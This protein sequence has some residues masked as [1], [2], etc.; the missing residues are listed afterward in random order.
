MKNCHSRYLSLGVI[1]L[2]LSGM[3]AF[4][5]QAQ[6]QSKKIEHR[7]HHEMLQTCAKACSDCQLACD[8]CTTHCG[9][10][11]HEGKKDHMTSMM[12]CQDC[13][14]ICSAAAQIMARGGPFANA[15][16]DSCAKACKDC[17]IVCE[18]F[19]QDEHMQACAKEC[20]KCEAACKKMLQH[21]GNN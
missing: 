20:R 18:K 2:T 11:L 21:L 10:Q 19:P 7:E 17:A 3:I 6:P 12:A 9:H 4:A 5:K 8:T 1:A 16:C 14:T 15:I 13:A